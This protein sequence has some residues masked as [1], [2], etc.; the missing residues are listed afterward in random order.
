MKGKKKFAP[1]FSKRGSFSVVCSCHHNYNDDLWVDGR[2]VPRRSHS[3]RV[4]APGKKVFLSACSMVR[5]DD[6]YLV[7]WIK[8]HQLLGMER[9]VLYLD[10]PNVQGRAKTKMILKEFVKSGLVVVN[11]W[12]VDLSPVRRFV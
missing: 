9:F 5:G 4:V 10:D 2:L 12:W 8:F 7:E 6:A 3:Q 1:L 11:D